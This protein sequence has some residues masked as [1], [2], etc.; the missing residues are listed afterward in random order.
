[1]KVGEAGFFIDLAIADPA[2]P[3]AYLLGIECDG[4]EYNRA[5]TARDRDRTRQSVLEGLGWCV[6]RLWSVE[7]F[8]HP[9]QEKERLLAAIQA[10]K[11]G[12]PISADV[13]TEEADQLREKRL[14]ELRHVRRESTSA[15]LTGTM[16][17]PEY[18]LAKPL[19][20]LGKKN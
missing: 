16:S 7:W 5:R 13:T 12:K 3:G 17:Q 6:Y 4:P 18:K 14:E 8:A 9:A 2:N 19:I 1:M 11:D 10:A 15:K 20:R